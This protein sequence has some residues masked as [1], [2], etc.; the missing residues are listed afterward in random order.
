MKK[1]LLQTV[2]LFMSIA[3]FAQGDNEKGGAYNT[4]YWIGQHLYYI[5]GGIAIIIILWLALRKKKK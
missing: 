4:G 5:L 3:A 1:F 2:L